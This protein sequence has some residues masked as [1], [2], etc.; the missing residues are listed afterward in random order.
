MKVR[1]Y[2]T[3]DGKTPFTK[4]LDRLRD[5]QAHGGILARIARL[6]LGLVGDTR[7]LGDGVYELKVNVGPGLS[8][9]L[10]SI[11]Q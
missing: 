8:R 6:Q 7:S 5:K 2:I 11:G 10:C 3:A 1:Y 4:W 9:L